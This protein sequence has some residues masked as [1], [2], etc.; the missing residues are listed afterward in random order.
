MF[1]TINSVL[2]VTATDVK[3]CWWTA[4]VRSISTAWT[5]SDELIFGYESGSG[6]TDKDEELCLCCQCP[7]KTMTIRN[8]RW[9]T[10]T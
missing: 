2:I 4:K 8:E 10:S 9:C 5:A 1:D 7:R 3:I 6:V